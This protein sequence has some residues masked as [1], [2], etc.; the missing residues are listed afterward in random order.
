MKKHPLVVAAVTLA[1]VLTGCVSPYDGSPDRTGT[2][3][4][5]GG[6]IGAG[7]GALIGSASGHAGEGA[8][9]GAAAGL[10]A[11][12]LIGHS[13][14][15]EEQTRLRAQAPQTYARVE[16][17][18]PLSVAD[19]KA[20]A[21]ARINDD[22]IIS[23][24]RNSRTVYRLSSA[25][26]IDLH[27]SGVSDKVIDYMINTAGSGGGAQVAPAPQ[28]EVVYVPQPPPPPRV[29]TV[30]MAPG[31]GYVWIGGEWMWNGGWVWT[32]GHWGYPPYPHSVWVGGNW[33]HGP[34]GWHRSPGHWRH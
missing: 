24:I 2:G 25:D 28:P 17:R 23:Q 31:P 34:R 18:Q 8:L 19:V 27:N 29:E 13:M 30:V 22:V 15:Q 11:G 32:G 26:I 7:S 5:T 10:I 1:V 14:D 21:Q 6:A 12:G 16:Q 9:I 4:L 33:N 3:A 20:L